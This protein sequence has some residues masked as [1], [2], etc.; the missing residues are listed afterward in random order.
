MHNPPDKVRKWLQDPYRFPISSQGEAQNLLINE[1]FSYP[2]RFETGDGADADQEAPGA[3]G[4]LL[5]ERHPGVRPG[6]F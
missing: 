4:L 2:K 6:I 5:P 1:V 3:D